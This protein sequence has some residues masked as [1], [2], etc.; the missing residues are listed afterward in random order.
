M[1]IT[2]SNLRSGTADNDINVDKGLS[3]VDW[4]YIGAVAG[5]SDTAWFLLDSS[6][7][8]L[9]WFWRVRPEFKQDHSFETDMALFKARTRFSVGFSDWRG[10]WGS[11]GDGAA[12]SG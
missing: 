12:Y 9:N 11:A 3:V 6:L 4:D 7:H 8:E 2:G 5:G 1:I 10:V